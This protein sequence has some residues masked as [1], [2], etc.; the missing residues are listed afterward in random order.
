MD[1]KTRSFRRRFEWKVLEAVG[2]EL[3]SLRKALSSLQEVGLLGFIFHLGV[4]LVL[5][6]PY[7]LFGWCS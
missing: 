2:F 6:E 7:G 3:P 4:I 5:V 1:T